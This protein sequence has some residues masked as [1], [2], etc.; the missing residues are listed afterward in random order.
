MEFCS[1]TIVE[2]CHVPF[3]EQNTPMK[4]GFLSFCSRYC[5]TF[6][7]ACINIEKSRLP[8]KSVFHNIL[9][10]AC[11]F[12]SILIFI[13]VV[14]KTA[15]FPPIGKCIL[16]CYSIH[17]VACFTCN[18]LDCQILLCLNWQYSD[19]KRDKIKKQTMEIPKQAFIHCYTEAVYLLLWIVSFSYFHSLP[20]SFIHSHF[21]ALSKFTNI[22]LFYGSECF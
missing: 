1:I 14:A 8:N 17:K 7:A 22:W 19:A 21:I 6:F 13:R 9:R 11:T 4:N 20:L 5:N 3:D 15:T 2:I 18:T 10:F 16:F 12:L